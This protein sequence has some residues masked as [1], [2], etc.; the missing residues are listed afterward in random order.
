MRQQD[1]ATKIADQLL[2]YNFLAV[3]DGWSEVEELVLSQA[4]GDDHREAL[5]GLLNR[6]KTEIRNWR[7][8]FTSPVAVYSEEFFSG[9]S[10]VIEVE[11]D[12][13]FANVCYAYQP[14]E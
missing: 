11:I 5:Q 7:N 12:S 9:R 1:K 6:A 2:L 14:E 4:N 8:E 13:Q 3:I 10:E